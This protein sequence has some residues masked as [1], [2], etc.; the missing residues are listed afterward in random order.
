[1][2]LSNHPLLKSHNKNTNSS[3]STLGSYAENIDKMFNI[4]DRRDKKINIIK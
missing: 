1:M 3:N 4:A 2:E